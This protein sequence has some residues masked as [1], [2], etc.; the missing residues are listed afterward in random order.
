MHVIII[1]DSKGQVISVNRA[2][3]SVAHFLAGQ[4]E[5]PELPGGA[6]FSIE[7]L[8]TAL[9]ANPKIEVSYKVGDALRVEYHAVFV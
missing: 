1:L 7:N 2:L 6:E 5:D 4:G 9:R 8:E 3:E